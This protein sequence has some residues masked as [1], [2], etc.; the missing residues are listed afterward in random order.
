MDTLSLLARLQSRLC[1]QYQTLAELAQKV[2]DHSA[3]RRYG[4]LAL[5][6]AAPDVQPLLDDWLL[7]LAAQ[8]DTSTRR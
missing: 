1:R 2:G 5:A 4:N 7:T 3:A 8:H 6:S